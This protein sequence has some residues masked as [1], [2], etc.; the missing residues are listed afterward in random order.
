MGAQTIANTI[1]GGSLL[2]LQY[3]RPQNPILIIKAPTLEL[4]RVWD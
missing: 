3:S 1:L 4:L 2:D